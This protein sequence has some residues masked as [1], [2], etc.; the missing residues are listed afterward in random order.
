MPVLADADVLVLSHGSKRDQA[1]A[2]NCD[3]FV[4]FIEAFKQL[5]HA[6]NAWRGVGGGIRD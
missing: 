6:A 1:M 4:A 2:A 5:T 3:S